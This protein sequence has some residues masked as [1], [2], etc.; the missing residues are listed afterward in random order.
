VARGPGRALDARPVVGA[1]GGVVGARCRFEEAE[2]ELL[3]LA[4]DTVRVS[5]LTD[6]APPPW[7][8]TDWAAAPPGS[9]VEPSLEAPGGPW[10]LRSPLL[11]VHVSPDGSV[12]FVSGTGALLRHE[13]PPIRRGTARTLR[14][15]LRPGERVAGLGEQAGPLDLSGS[16]HRL[17][18]RDPGGA[19]GPGQDPLY[20]PLPVLVGLHP[21]GAVLVVHHNPSEALVRIDGQAQP[22]GRARQVEV[23][24][25][26]GMLCHFVATG[27]L[28]DLCE[29]LGELTG[30]PPLPPRW[31]LGYHQSRWGYEREADVREVAEGFRAAGLPLS[32]V[33][34]DIDHLDGYRVLTVDARRFPDLGRLG[35]DLL[36]DGTR[37]VAIVDP[38]VKVD[39]GFDVY[40]EGLEGGRFVAGSR[41]RPHVG[42]GWPG[43]SVF[44]D[45]V[46]PTAA[47]WW[48]DL[49]GRLADRGV[50][51]VWHDLNEPTSLS[52][53]GDRTL[54]AQ[55]RHGGSDG[56]LHAE[57]HNVYGLLMDR[58]G[59]QGLE[60][61]RPERRPFVL[62][63][64]GWLGVQRWAF[65]WTGDAETSWD[66]L[67][68]Q[69]PTT[70]GL[71][72]SGVAFAGSDT[73]G[74]SAAADPELYLRWLELSVLMPF[75]RTHSAKGVPAREPW[76]FPGPFA[77]AIGR[78]IRFRYRLLPYLYAL[79]RDAADRGSPLVRPLC[80]E[81]ETPWRDDEYLLGDSLLVAPVGAPGER[82]RQVHLPAGQWYRWRIGPPANGSGSQGDGAA[83]A[84]GPGPAGDGD[85]VEPA[86]VAG[87]RTLTVDAP[88]GQPV[89]FVRA[90]TVLPL[91]DGWA[92][93]PG[94][95]GGTDDPQAGFPQPGGRLDAGHEPRLLSL[96]CFPDGQG[97][98][99]GRGYDD[100]G[101]GHGPS[102]RDR[103]ELQVP[104]RGGPDGRLTW[105]REGLY[106]PP[107]RV[108]VVVHGVALRAATA[109]GDAVAVS[110]STDPPVT[111]LE[112]G[113]FDELVLAGGAPG[114][115][116]SRRA[117]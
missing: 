9:P 29:R 116:R 3:F 48:G 77:A 49:Y 86:P 52:L 97:R 108:R 41:G 101:D 95:L 92:G 33:H 55:A 36:A 93:G 94:R 109:G 80:W 73:G 50:G 68:Q 61:C 90:G 58:A 34:L 20:C 91:D 67:R 87:G 28:P 115:L 114:A 14:A 4:P 74:F 83:S 45:V 1:G 54:P 111:V 70:L 57:C 40:R 11:S 106:P 31:A 2:L 78:L 18:A 85:A 89:V 105:V 113:A 39:L 24:F 22:P 84:G 46:S 51:G 88:L 38:T 103:F 65:L 42:A 16:A 32:A 64:S 104:A 26:S 107:A 79:A 76:R 30:R 69:L 8:I 60:R 35:A 25:A 59:W 98:A 15:L 100:A 43:P 99:T 112:T 37:L 12:R 27:T 13:L 117:P 23:T 21:D 6:Q 10:T 110:A 19:W 44:V 17:W 71:A 5:W 102:R 62:S 66:G 63:R 72:L 7:G 82:A 81:A 75:C 47:R 53:W 56:F 96:H